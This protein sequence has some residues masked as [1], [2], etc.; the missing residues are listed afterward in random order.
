MLCFRRIAPGLF[1]LDS[2]GQLPAAQQGRAP[3]FTLATIFLGMT[4]ISVWLALS[5]TS[6]PYGVALLVVLVPATIRTIIIM[7]FGGHEGRPLS[8]RDTIFAFVASV[9]AVLLAAVLSLLL[10][11][12]PFGVFLA[13][14]AFI[15]MLFVTRPR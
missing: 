5:R 10:A 1:T 8:V 2:N 12:I 11:C 4:L 13:P 3:K 15:Y 9:S 6:W 14:I 7:G